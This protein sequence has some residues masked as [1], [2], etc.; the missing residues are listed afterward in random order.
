M[1]DDIKVRRRMNSVFNNVAFDTEY[2]KVPIKKVVNSYGKNILKHL[3]N[4]DISDSDIKKYSTNFN[5]PKPQSMDL[6]IEGMT[7]IIFGSDGL[8]K[9][10]RSTEK[11]KKTKNLENFK[12]K[13]KLFHKFKVINIK[14]ITEKKE[15]DLF[16]TNFKNL[17]ITQNVLT[18]LNHSDSTRNS[19][20]RKNLPSLQ[21][22][23]NFEDEKIEFIKKFSRNK[24]KRKCS[25]IY[26]DNINLLKQ[27]SH[28]SLT[29]YSK[30]FETKRIDYE[31]DRKIFG[32]IE[33]RSE[34]PSAIKK[35]STGMVEYFDKPKVD[36]LKF[37]DNV[38]KMH[39]D[40]IIGYKSYL[41]RT[42]NTFAKNAKVEELSTITKS[43]SHKRLDINNIT[44]QKLK[45]KLNNK[46][47]TIVKT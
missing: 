38:N 5:K 44:L 23:N 12:N 30:C 26:K 45:Y 47:D 29:S 40:M 21:L 10:L 17:K 3:N 18:H 1:N 22:E 35:K 16:I 9:K 7:K 15:S 14:P 31:T 8:I 13:R 42:Y 20:H 36:L 19:T 4:M 25:E 46:L 24:F 27:F 2:D 43:N 33:K 39:D 37:G 41:E 34:F 6:L 11:P 28:E 32:E